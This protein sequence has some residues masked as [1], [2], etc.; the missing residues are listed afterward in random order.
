[1][2]ELWRDQYKYK[3]IKGC[4]S[5]PQKQGWGTCYFTVDNS[6][7]YLYYQLKEGAISLQEQQTSPENIEAYIKQL[8]D[9]QRHHTLFSI[10]GH[11]HTKQD[12]SNQNT[13]LGEIATLLVRMNVQNKNNTMNWFSDLMLIPLRFSLLL[14]QCK[15]DLEPGCAHVPCFFS[16]TDRIHKSCRVPLNW[17]STQDRNCHLLEACSINKVY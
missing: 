8:P 7:A 5:Q 16:T 3:R 12:I 14:R 10:F 6:V 15:T 13:A 17:S 4:N 9:L 2:Q 11:W 1:M